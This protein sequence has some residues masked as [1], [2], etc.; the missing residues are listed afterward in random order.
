MEW[1]AMGLNNSKWFGMTFNYTVL[2]ESIM[3]NILLQF[4]W[5]SR[6]TRHI[7]ILI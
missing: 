6:M 1:D 3:S 2:M 4:N 5:E 7:L